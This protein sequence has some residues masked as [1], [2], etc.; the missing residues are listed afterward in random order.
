MPGDGLALSTIR[1][2]DAVAAADWD[3]CAGTENPFVSYAFLSALE[4]SGSVGGRSGWTPNHLLLRDAAGRLIGCTPLYLKSHSYGEY[5][6]DHG[7]A[8]AYESAGGR[9]YPKLLSAVPFSPVPGPRLLLAPD[10]PAN[11]A[12]R[13][14][15]GM[16][17]VAEQADLSSVHVNFATE[18]QCAALAE[19]GFMRRI[20]L[21]FHWENDGYASFED[22]LGALASRKRK[23]IRKERRE[24]LDG[25]I[26]IVTLTGKE[27]T[28]RHWDA[29]HGF[30]LSTIDRKWGSAYL[31]RRF[32]DLLGE[33][34]G[35]KV[36]LILAQQA[37]VPIGAALNLR[38]ADTLYG[39]NWG[40][41]GEYKFLHFEACY[42][43]A[44]DYAIAHGL[45]RVEAGAQGQHK[46]LR[47]YLPVLTYSAH[48][49]AQAGMAK[50]VA[51]FLDRESRAVLEQRVELETL[52]P[53]RK[54]DEG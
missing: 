17:A 8:Q 34:L 4:D 24:A 33:R 46:I 9:Y 43:R 48:W 10:A 49:F 7:W 19:A 14:I 16:V 45:K 31:T 38:G 30:Y 47:G 39:R 52:S 11:A 22:F 44:I 51:H 50:A 13:L 40:A 21:Q 42:Y 6:F 53:F 5:V 1:R 28:K 3:R 29:F 26:E 2:L 18:A 25:G 41:S 15:D 32:F 27:I 35:D 23:Q 54:G 20:G 37:G 36:V 12:G